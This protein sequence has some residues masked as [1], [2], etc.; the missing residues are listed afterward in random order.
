MMH[1]DAID[2]TIVQ[3]LTQDARQSV[4]T[5][6]GRV[7]LSPSAAG[8]R[9]RRLRAGGVLAGFTVQ[10]D[11][12]GVGRPIDALIDVELDAAAGYQALDGTL[13]SLPQIVD[14]LRLTG[15]HDYQ[16]RVHAR[17]VEDLESVIVALKDTGLV[18]TTATRLVLRTSP[19]MPRPPALV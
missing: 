9:L 3:Q 10:I 2:R 1:L 11:P 5:L 16:L 13:E 6:A 12:V 14:A 15:R 19:G 4:R 17:S 7:G 18:R 8:E